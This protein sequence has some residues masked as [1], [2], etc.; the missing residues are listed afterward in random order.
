MIS[1]LVA[2]TPTANEIPSALTFGTTSSTGTTLERMRITKD[3]NIGIGTTTPASEL[4]VSGTVRAEQICDEAGANCRDISAGWGSGG[5]F[6]ADGSVPMTGSFL[7]AD[8][9]AATPGISFN[10]DSDSGIFL[11]GSNE[12]AFSNAGTPSVLINASGNV[13]IGT[14]TASEKLYVSYESTDLYSP[15]SGTL[16]SPA[17]GRVKFKN[18]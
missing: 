5:D 14:Q 12:I 4:D 7:A 9:T 1:A 18:A 3:G 8:G 10:N 16:R 17:G 6:L 2:D 13:G 15:S 11:S